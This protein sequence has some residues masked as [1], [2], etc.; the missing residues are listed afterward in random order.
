MLGTD[1]PA[2]LTSSGKEGVM[3][4]DVVLM[5]S[6]VQDIN[7][8]MRVCE[9]QRVGEGL[10]LGVFV[11]ASDKEV[12]PVLMGILDAPR[13]RRQSIRRVHAQSRPAPFFPHYHPITTFR[14]PFTDF[15]VGQYTLSRLRIGSDGCTV[16]ESGK[17]RRVR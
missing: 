13:D 16:W 12:R 10:G 7:T 11:S 2:V 14:P 9:L 4:V 1:A 5:Y 8:I 15:T 6:G 3:T 17:C